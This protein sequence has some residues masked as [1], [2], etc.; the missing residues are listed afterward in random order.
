VPTPSPNDISVKDPMNDDV[1]IRVLKTLPELEEIRDC[2]ESWGGN[3]D[4]QIDSY[5]SVLQ[6]RPDILR[7]HV[8]V[9]YRRGRPETILVGRIDRRRLDFKVGYARLRPKATVMYFVYGG[10]RGST[11][12]ENSLAVVNE[13]CRSLARGEADAAY[14]NFLPTDSHI[15]ELARRIPAFLTRDRVVDIQQH[16]SAS[17]PNSA[18]GFY[19]GLSPNTRWQARSKQKKL[20]RDLSGA[21]RIRCFRDSGEIDDLMQ[22]VE[23]VAHKSYQRGLKVGFVDSAETRHRLALKAEKEWLR[24]YVLYVAD[25]PS[26]FWIGDLNDGTFGSEYLGYDQAL[27]RYSPGM[28]LITKVIEGFCAEEP[29]RVKEVDFATGHAQYK[30]A[31][32]NRHWQEGAL[33]IFAPSV[34][35]LYLNGCRNITGR[36]SHV[37]RQSLGRTALLQRVKK[38]WRKAARQRAMSEA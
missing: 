9:L 37:L 24:A 28:Y 11:S 16:Y 29:Q 3:R 38:F 36:V 13:I 1:Q 33:Y 35:G 27:G 18:E 14:L 17:L 4:S 25:Q 5:L 8:I 19:K 7:P 30:E 32:G 21:V 12:Y 20:V 10:L 23:Q 6:A 26:A 34:R 2:W 22:D 15:Y 31:L